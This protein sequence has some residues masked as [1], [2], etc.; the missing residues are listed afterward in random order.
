[1]DS[2]PVVDIQGA[3]SAFETQ[4]KTVYEEWF[5]NFGPRRFMMRLLFADGRLLRED[6]LGYGYNQLG[7]DCNASAFTRGVSTGELVARCGQPTSRRDNPS[8]IVRRDSVGNEHIRPR[9]NEEWIYDF[10]DNQFLRVLTIING[11]IESVN[12]L[13]R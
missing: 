10:S 4:Q 5:Y 3:G 12:E 11:R 7:Q 8:A 13:R 6:E 1:M 9:R 2:Y